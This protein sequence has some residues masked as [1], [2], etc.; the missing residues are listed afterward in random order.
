MAVT[1]TSNGSQSVTAAALVSRLAARTRADPVVRDVLGSRLMRVGDAR[2]FP[3]GVDAMACTLARS[4]L[5]E[6]VGAIALAFPRGLG[7]HPALL[8]L[9]L[10]FWRHAA[11]GRLCG[12]VSVATR[13]GDLVRKLKDVRLDGQKFQELKIG[14]LVREVVPNSAG[15]DIFGTPT[16]PRKRAAFRPLAGGRRELLSQ[17]HGYLLFHPPMA[18]PPMPNNV[19]WAMV[20]DT[21]G[22]GRPWHGKS[23]IDYPDTWTQTWEDNYAAGRQQVW[24]GET[25]DRDFEVFCAD[26]EVPVVW[27]DWPLISACASTE[28][29]CGAGPLVSSGMCRRSSANRQSLVYHVVEDVDRDQLVGELYEMLRKIRRCGRD[30]RG[31]AAIK[32]AYEVCSRVSR[33]AAPASY[34]EAE[35]GRRP[36]ARTLEQLLG[37]LHATQRSAFI[38]R[39]WKEAFDRYWTLVVSLCRRLSELAA[40]ERCAKYEALFERVALAERHGE[41]VRVLCQSETERLALRAALAELGV[42]V[43]VA[44]F[45]RRLHHGD[46][47]EHELTLL[48]GAPPPWQGH[49][50]LTGEAGQLEVL[51]YRHEVDRLRAIARSLAD[52]AM[53]AAANSA[54]LDALGVS[55]RNGRIGAYSAEPEAAPVALTHGM[56]FTRSGVK[57]DC[58]PVSPEVT[59]LDTGL[60]QELIMLW[61]TDLAD[62]ASDSDGDDYPAAVTAY[63]GYAR[64]VTFTDGSRVL[65]RDDGE[66]DVLGVDDEG[67]EDIVARPPGELARGDRIAF[68]P[69]AGRRSLLDTLMAAHDERLAA[70]QRML[71]PLY[72]RALDLAVAEHGVEGLAAIVG[73]QRFSV[74][75]WLADRAKPGTKTAF[76]ALLRASGDDDAWRARAPIWEYL[77]RKRGVH[78]YIGRLMRK[79]IA[80]GLRDD[81]ARPA[82]ARLGEVVRRNDLEDL[83]DQVEELEVLRVSPSEQLPLRHC[84]RYLDLDDPTMAAFL[85]ERGIT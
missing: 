43:P 40:G 20:V 47:R 46:G 71:E 76:E 12:S 2:V 19:V 67:E 37:E 1:A 74:W 16:P 58:E 6:K 62:E 30:D 38:G 8:G 13:Q 59:P 26:R 56:T 51:C 80:E 60:W 79:A 23:D 15:T 73:R 53:I 77:S 18:L 63:C 54:S 5:D 61:G 50:L 29:G 33:M 49:I 31:P 44:S 72:R 69:G 27:F 28:Y 48:V 70:E 78:R 39:H 84:G 85:R 9:Y 52:P 81:G 22:A 82:L 34:Y 36:G 83:F 75:D 41:R 66:V 14:R 10:A 3:S 24:L 17:R 4:L 32:V 25:G 65:F 7:P 35:Y 11:P 21:I 42:D 68:L 55:S 45:S 57:G 64:E